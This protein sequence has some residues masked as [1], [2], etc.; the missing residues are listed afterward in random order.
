ML[1]KRSA[2]C[3]TFRNLSLLLSISVPTDIHFGRDRYQSRYCK[4]FQYAC[5]ADLWVSPVRARLI[6]ETPLCTALHAMHFYLDFVTCLAFCL[7]S[8]V[9]YLIVIV[10]QSRALV[11]VAEQNV[12][13]WI[14]SMSQGSVPI[15]VHRIRY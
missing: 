4:H 15:T 14:K 5:S 3:L 8:S 10:T 1:D 11:L 7:I 13:S 9:M 2:R 6:R 12:Q